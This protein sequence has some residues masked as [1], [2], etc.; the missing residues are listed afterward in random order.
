ME[1]GLLTPDDFDFAGGSAVLL[2]PFYSVAPL[3]RLEAEEKTH[4]EADK[5]LT[6]EESWIRQG[7]KARR[8]RN[9]GRVRSLKKM[10]EQRA[11]RRVQTGKARISTQEVERSGRIVIEARGLCFAWPGQPILSNF[12]TIIQRGDK[13]GIIGPNGCGKSTLVNLLLGKLPPDKGELKLG[14]KLKPAYFDQ[15]R[16]LLDPNKTVQDNIT[17]DTDLIRFNG[18]SRHVIGYLRDF[19]FSPRAGPVYH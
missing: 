4:S 14:T 15:H 9:E 19:L 11:L 16:T 10:R 13:I 3:A 5:H 12:S 1:W 2:A 8:S 17:G 6:R 18:Q 7:I